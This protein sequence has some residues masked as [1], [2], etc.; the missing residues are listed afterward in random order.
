MGDI[1]FAYVRN[2]AEENRKDIW[3]EFVIPRYFDSLEVRRQ[4]KAV[5]IEGGRGCGKTTLLRYLS[6][7]SQFSPKRTG[8]KLE[9]LAFIGI[10]WKLD[11]NFLN[12]FD[13]Q[14][15]EQSRWIS[16]F[17]HHMACCLALEILSSLSSIN[18]TAERVARFGGVDR[19]DFSELRSFDPSLPTDFA[20]LNSALRSRKD[21]LATWLNN[22]H[23]M[24]AP[25][26]LPGEQF[27]V[28][29][30]EIVKEQLPYLSDALF[31]VFIDEYE[32]LPDYQQQYVNGL[33]KCAVAPLLFNIAMKPNGM[34]TRQ[35]LLHESIQNTADYRLIDLESLLRREFGEFAAELLFF[36]LVESRPEL[37][38]LVPI[39][40]STLRDE[41]SL[42][43]RREGAYL[44][45]LMSAAR[46]VLP[47]KTE[48]QLAQDILA[49]DSLRGRLERQIRNGLRAWGSSLSSDQFIRE[50]AAQASVVCSALL[51]RKKPRP[52]EILKQLQEFAR[53][54]KGPFE[55]WISNNLFGVELQLY[56]PLEKACPLYSGFDALVLMARSNVRYFLELIHQIFRDNVD[57]NESGIPCIAPELQAESVRSAS[58][59]MVEQIHGC[60]PSS[61]YLHTFATSLGSLFAVKHGHAS[62]SEPEINQFTIAS[63]ELSAEADLHLREAEKWSVVLVSEETKM[64]SAGAASYDYFL[65]P[66]FSACYGYSYR[67][68]RSIPL[69]ARDVLT[70]FVASQESRDKLVATLAKSAG[71]DHDDLFSQEHGDD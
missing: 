40:P 29:L 3:E 45:R 43:E 4:L 14:E 34:R 37:A 13:S 67:K 6:H 63:G 24:Q 22:L 21:A 8:L 60:G 18:C 27:L 41:C 11:V 59:E 7:A 56:Q 19:L 35:T 26:F 39:T 71:D 50:D 32:N 16:A 65:H 55:N 36:R 68:K 10:Y 51:S 9:H 2:R 61:T 20:A 53:T 64:K 33:M 58:R 52:E 31:S 17:K 62:Q 66:A 15:L 49:S 44:E 28:R 25:L 30:V 47:R 70:L 57:R 23:T 12:A 1:R 46:E 69:S 54:G 5:V 42:E 38:R 48:G